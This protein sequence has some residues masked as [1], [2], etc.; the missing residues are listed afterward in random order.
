MLVIYTIAK[1]SQSVKAKLQK[2]D[3]KGRFAKPLP[4]PS[5]VE[6]NPLVQFDYPNSQN[7]GIPSTRTVRLISSTQTHFTGLE[8]LETGKWKFKKFLQPKARQFKVLSFNPAS[9]S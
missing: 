4:K 1:F 7:Y 5:A 6:N 2:R 3:R 9:M 8:K